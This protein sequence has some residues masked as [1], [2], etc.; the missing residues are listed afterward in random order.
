MVTRPAWASFQVEGQ[1]VAG[2]VE[3]VGEDAGCQP[4]GA[5][6]HQGAEHAQPLGMGQGAEGGNGLGLVHD[7]I[8]QHY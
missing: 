4:F 2:H 8:I 3:L 1:G 6:D 7:S 5:G